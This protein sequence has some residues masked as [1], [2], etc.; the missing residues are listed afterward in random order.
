LNCE[1]CSIL[2]AGNHGPRGIFLRLVTK[3][4]GVKIL[5]S[6]FLALVLIAGTGIAWADRGHE[7]EHGYRHSHFGVGIEIGPYWGPWYYHP[8]AY[9]APYYYPPVVVAPA[10]PPVYIQQTPAPAPAPAPQVAYWYYCS[11][12]KSYYPYV[13]ECP[14]GWQQ[15]APQP[16]PSP[17]P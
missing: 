11:A 5:K 7:H 12:S 6:T 2:A 1:A 15:V 8:Y 4:D 3:E 13:R 14:G 16:T 17:Q 10:A 9:P